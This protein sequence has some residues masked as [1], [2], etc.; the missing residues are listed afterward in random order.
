VTI[1]WAKCLRN[2][3]LIPDRRKRYLSSQKHPNRLWI[4]S[5]LL[6]SGYQELF[7]WEVWQQWCEANQ[8]SPS[9]VDVKMS[10]AIM[11]TSANAYVTDTGTVLTFT[12]F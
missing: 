11:S 10:V 4:P 1:P 5:K 6:F 3:G 8:S 9:G 7:P 12:W 2:C